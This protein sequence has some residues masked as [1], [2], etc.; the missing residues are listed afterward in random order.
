MKRPALSKTTA[1]TETT[2]TSTP[3]VKGEGDGLGAWADAKAG[4]RSGQARDR[5]QSAHQRVEQGR[6]T[7]RT[8]HGKAERAGAGSSRRR[9][10]CP[11][12]TTSGT[13]TAS[14]K[15]ATVNPSS[16]QAE[17][18]VG[19]AA[20]EARGD[21][22]QKRLGRV[23]NQGRGRPHRRAQ[24]QGGERVL[25]RAQDG[26]GQQGSRGRAQD[27]GD[28]IEGM[29]HRGD[30]VREHLE[31][32][33]QGEDREGLARGEELERRAEIQKARAGEAA[34]EQ[35][36][37]PGPKTGAGGE[38]YGERH[39]GQELGEG[40]RVH[41]PE[42]RAAPGESQGR[43]GRPTGKPARPTRRAPRA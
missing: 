8:P 6:V 22:A 25:D 38:R 18:G 33:R 10:P 3:T 34:R 17:R 21:R 32:G 24:G 23:G 41:D 9:P 15:N 14:A 26:G 37:K 30:L 19:Q 42:R 4:A 13:R 29:V 20:G 5:P 2:L 1:V 39:L 28:R 35:Q 11:A 12:T 40:R 27:G 7:R 16:G 31:D 36:G 43:G